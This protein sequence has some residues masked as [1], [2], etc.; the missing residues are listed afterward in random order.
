VSID[1]GGVLMKVLRRMEKAYY[2]AAYRGRVPMND[3]FL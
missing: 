3:I 1:E 2:K